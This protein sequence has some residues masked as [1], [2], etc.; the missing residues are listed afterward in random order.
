MNVVNMTLHFETSLLT[1][2]KSPFGLQNLQ[3]WYLLQVINL[4]FSEISNYFVRC[5]VIPRVL[6]AS[7]VC[8]VCFHRIL[9]RSSLYSRKVS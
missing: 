6:V 2:Q 1:Y 9:V 4:I 8:G 5:G 3:E 7:N